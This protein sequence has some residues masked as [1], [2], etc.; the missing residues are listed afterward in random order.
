ML[1]ACLFTSSLALTSAE[2]LRPQGAEESAAFP[3]LGLT[4]KLPKLDSIERKEPQVKSCKGDWSGR[5]KASEVRLRLNVLSQSNY[6]FLEPEDVVEAWRDSMCSP[7]DKQSEDVPFQYS[8]EGMRSLSGPFGCSPILALTQASVH[9]KDDANT[10]GLVILAGGLLPDGGWSLR[11][12]AW[13]APSTEDA[14]ALVG[15]IEKCA[16]YQGKMRDP[17]WTD[18]E[19]L[20][21]WKKVAPESTF[22]KF[23][24]PTR[25]EHFIVLTNSNAPGPYVKKL[26][27]KY[28][29]IRKALPF[30]DLKGR[31]LLPIL[32]FRTDDDFQ[33][34]YRAVYKMAPKDDV[35]EGS[36]V[37]EHYLATSCDNGDDYEDLIDLTKLCLINRQRA[38]D[39]GRWFRSGLREYVAS[40]PKERADSLRAV[41]SGK[42][43]PLEKLL[44]NEAWGKQDRK[45][46]KRGASDEADYWGQSA[47]WMEFLHDG[48]WPKDKFAHFVQTVGVIPDEDKDRV[49]S[50][51]EAIY[52]MDLKALEKK[53]VEYFTK[54]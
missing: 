44:D 52:G 23:E 22:K 11:L 51:I 26:E 43:T 21:Y 40:K 13:P 35:D 8:F 38:W 30:E 18:E 7:S 10:K 6:D 47:M 45:I 3:E 34:Y 39:G 49:R 15:A 31:K 2:P 20:A 36:L 1:V 14:A 5:L 29:T 50:A 41:K 16:S 25:T 17:K 4:L 24:K 54:H 48:P 46:S 12:D 32:L 53:W 28:A 42:Y 33:A 37:L 9:K 27:G 19:A